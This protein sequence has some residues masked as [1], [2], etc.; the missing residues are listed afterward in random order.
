MDRQLSQQEL[1]QA[2]R[3]LLLQ[4]KLRKQLRPGVELKPPAS[5]ERDWE[6][7]DPFTGQRLKE[8]FKAPPEAMKRMEAELKRWQAEE[9][10]AEAKPQP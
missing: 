4:A 10:K 5:W 7:V 9:A 2:G 1:K 8:E 3:E 6:F